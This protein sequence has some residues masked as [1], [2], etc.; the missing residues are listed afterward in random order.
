VISTEVGRYALSVEGVETINHFAEADFDEAQGW[1]ATVEPDLAYGV[2]KKDGSL[3]LLLKPE[4]IV[5]DDL[6]KKLKKLAA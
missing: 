5:P 4:A 1:L 2:G 3:C 6:R